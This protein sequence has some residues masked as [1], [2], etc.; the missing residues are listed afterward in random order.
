MKLAQ[1]VI[2]GMLA[3]T[4]FA[5]TA[6]A[7]HKKQDTG[8]IQG[9][10][11][12]STAVADPSTIAHCP[13]FSIAPINIANETSVLANLS[14]GPSI[15]IITI[16]QNKPAELLRI[17]D[18][19]GNMLITV[20]MDGSVTTDNGYKADAAAKDFWKAL[21]AYYKPVCNQAMESKP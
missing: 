16:D 9:C 4:A 5:Q 19:D 6:K 7:P 17:K 2:A 11:E 10:K 13:E 18:A 15:E 14:K 20:H 8:E 1:I 3:G 21:A 12:A